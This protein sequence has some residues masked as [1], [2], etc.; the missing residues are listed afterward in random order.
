MS[1]GPVGSG[2]T[3]D[4]PVKWPTVSP[5]RAVDTYN[6]STKVKVVKTSVVGNFD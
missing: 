6:K 5:S 2:G 4:K 3:K 1:K